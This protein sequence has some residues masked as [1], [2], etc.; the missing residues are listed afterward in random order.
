MFVADLFVFLLMFAI[1]LI[2]LMALVLAL[3]SELG[4]E[5]VRILIGFFIVCNAVVCSVAAWN[6][7][8]IQ[9]VG[10]ISESLSI[11]QITRF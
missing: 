7:S 11:S 8:F 3:E 6:M 2:L 5:L 1:Y 4:L 9:S 10:R